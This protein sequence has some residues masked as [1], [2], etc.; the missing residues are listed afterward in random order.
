MILEDQVM[1]EDSSGHTSEYVTKNIESEFLSSTTGE[2]KQEHASEED[3]SSTP[4]FASK[5]SH[6]SY[7]A[8]VTHTPFPW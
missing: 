4:S 5:P 1:V 6:L 2:D 7:Q 8:D 3:D